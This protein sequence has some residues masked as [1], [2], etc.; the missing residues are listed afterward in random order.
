MAVDFVA[1][2]FDGVDLRTLEQ[3]LIDAL[4]GVASDDGQVLGARRQVGVAGALAVFKSK[5]EQGCHDLGV[6]D[7]VV[8]N[9]VSSPFHNRSL[10]RPMKFRSFSRSIED[11]ALSQT[12]RPWHPTAA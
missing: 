8:L 11:T 4:T 2:D 12:P 5:R 1:P 3:A 10:P 7:K 6:C 9:L